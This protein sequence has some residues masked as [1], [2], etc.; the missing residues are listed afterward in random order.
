MS[1]G[2]V[3]VLG[4]NGTGNG[5]LD[6]DSEATISGGTFVA[7]GSSGMAQNF[8]DSSTQ[9]SI[10]VSVGQQE[11]GSI[12]KL[13]DENKKELLSWTAEKSFECVLISCPDIQKGSTYTV[14]EGGKGA[15][16]RPNGGNRGF[17]RENQEEPSTAESAN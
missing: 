3:Y 7:V 12:V 5:M 6:Y 16:G 17:N 15:G 11:A 13:I 2:E 4:P 1:G 8:G 10:L 14:S 9:G